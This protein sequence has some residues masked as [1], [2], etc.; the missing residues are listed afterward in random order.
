MASGTEPAAIGTRRQFVDIRVEGK[1]VAT[2]ALNV[3]G[4]LLIVTGKRLGIAR[5]RGE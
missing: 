1:W 5:I 2:P 3:N 4:D